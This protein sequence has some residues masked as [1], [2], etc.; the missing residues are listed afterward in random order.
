MFFRT[1]S[2]S[3][4][5]GSLSCSISSAT[6]KIHYK[7]CKPSAS[8]VWLKRQVSTVV[9]NRVD[10]LIKTYNWTGIQ[11]VSEYRRYY[12]QQNLAAAVLGFTGIDSKGLEGLEYKYQ[13]LLQGK[14][15][16]YIAKVLGKDEFSSV[17][18]RDSQYS[19]LG[20]VLTM[21]HVIQY[22]TE[23]ALR[24]EFRKQ[25]LLKELALVMESNTEI[26]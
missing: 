21:D 16:M 2:K 23:N 25:N 18:G 17:F 20:L 9:A 8:F 3:S 22:F 11:S 13:H 26:F 24:K 10:Q 4:T 19:K 5:N 7:K 1:T 14:K 6:E 12:P 15:L